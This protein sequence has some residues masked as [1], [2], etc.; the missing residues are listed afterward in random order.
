[1]ANLAIAANCFFHFTQMLFQLFDLAFCSVIFAAAYRG[2]IPL[3]GHR[4]TN[5]FDAYSSCVEGT[6]AGTATSWKWCV[7]RCRASWVFMCGTGSHP[8]CW[9]NGKGPGKWKLFRWC[10][11]AMWSNRIGFAEKTALQWG[12]VS[13]VEPTLWS[14]WACH[15]YADWVTTWTCK[16]VFPKGTFSMLRTDMSG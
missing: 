16:P 4:G 6:N 13:A 2:L 15:V 12:H 7:L 3:T 1:M 10:S 9:H 5:A 11:C 14:F 8:S